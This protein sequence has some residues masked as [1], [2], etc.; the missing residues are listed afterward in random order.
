VFA[1]IATL[2]LAAVLLSFGQVTSARGQQAPAVDP[3][4]ARI[5]TLSPKPAWI[6]PDPAKALTRIGVG[7]CLDQKK[8]QPIWAD[9]I[10]EKPDLFL[11]LGDNVYGS[12]N[13]PDATL[14]IE[15]YA[16]Q[17]T[18][19]EF[20]A[21]RAAMPFLATWDDH[22]YGRNDGG[23]SYESKEIAAEAFRTFWQ[24]EHDLPKKTGAIY[25]SRVIGPVGRRVQIIMLDPRYDRSE[26]LPKPAD[27][28]HW[29][30]YGPDGDTTKS[31]LGA[32]QW[33]W[34]EQQLKEP[35][36]VRLLASG[37]QFLAEGHGFERWGNLP[38]ERE[39][40]LKLIDTTGAK[41]VV[42]L[43]GDRHHAAFYR[44][45]DTTSYPLYEMTASSLNLAYGPS[46]D[47]R[48]PPL[49]SD[50]VSVE[51]YGMIDIDWARGTILLAIK[52]IGRDAKVL[53]QI[54]FKEIGI[55]P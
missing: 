50:I 26:L 40:L 30:R 12:S 36:E 28:P 32:E 55:A 18:Q 24:M 42:M 21:A 33:A 9:I 34:L 43:S 49:V 46:K 1:L 7:S 23:A 4:K 35:A 6:K 17:A 20:A 19:I 27:F 14:L 53:Q 44:K 3:I 52:G 45:A 48:V 8:P 51:N 54:S 16:Q 13:A 22:D 10:N 11:M 47:A 29:G 38:H 31:M 41:G 5:A 39:R 37:I 2:L 25:Y 15:S